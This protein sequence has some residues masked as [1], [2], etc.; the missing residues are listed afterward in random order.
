MDARYVE[1]AKATAI[2]V[3]PALGGVRA[4]IQRELDASTGQT[5]EALLRV[6][7]RLKEREK[8]I[9]DLASGE[10]TVRE[11]IDRQAA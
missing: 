7:E 4:D 5:A 1:H 9:A 11:V 6:L 10:V 3:E 2:C 8:C